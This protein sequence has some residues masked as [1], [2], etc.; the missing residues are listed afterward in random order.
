MSLR[1]GVVVPRTGRLSA[2]GE[3][4]DFV[5]ARFAGRARIFTADSRSTPEGARRAVERL[6]VEHRVPIVLTM[7]GSTVLPAAADACDRLGVPCLSTTLPWQLYRS[8]GFH[9]AWGLDDIA[10][11]FAELWDRVAER[12]TVG[13]L[14]NDGMQGAALRRGFLPACRDRV[15]VHEPA[16]TERTPDFAPQIAAFADVDVVTS[17]ATAADL[18]AF[19]AQAAPPR[20]VTCSRWLT[21][22]F[23]VRRHNLDRVATI[24]YWTPDHPY[25]SSVDGTTAAE[26]ASAYTESTGRPWA[27]PLGLAHALFEVALHAFAHAADPTDPAALAEAIGRARVPT[28]AGPIDWP[29][30]PAPG[31][32]AVALAGGQWQGGDLVVVANTGAPDA[33]IRGDLLVSRSA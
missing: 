16:Y 24:V 14:W 9:F 18:A 28:I 33:P 4:L 7:A 21:Y 31:V 8:S 23:G 5:A 12:A 30:G 25:V 10:R 15:M 22:P 29:G 32:A 3:P 17:A 13:C 6:V 2:L 26:L 1:I 11:A 27:Q 20:L 19:L